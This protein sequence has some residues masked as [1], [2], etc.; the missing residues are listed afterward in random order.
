[1]TT[2]QKSEA[3]LKRIVELNQDINDRTG[4]LFSPDWSGNSL[5]VAFKDGHTHCGNPEGNFKQLIDSLHD[6]LCENK[7]LSLV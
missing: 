4:I 6:M 3:I 7:G 2:Q 1:M 5:T